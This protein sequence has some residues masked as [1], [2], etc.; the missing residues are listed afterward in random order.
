MKQTHCHTFMVHSHNETLRVEFYTVNIVQQRK[1]SFSLVWRH[2]S[3]QYFVSL[4]VIIIDKTVIIYKCR[5]TVE[6]RHGEKKALFFQ[7]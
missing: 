1:V 6:W 4:L 3:R 2:L 7:H 5:I